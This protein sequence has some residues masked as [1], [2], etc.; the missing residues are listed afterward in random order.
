MF[1]PCSTRSAYPTF[2]GRR[3]TMSRFRYKLG[4]LIR[5]TGVALCALVLLL[6]ACGG[7]SSSA[8]GTTVSTAFA[9]AAGAKTSGSE[10]TD[11]TEF[12]LDPQRSDATNRPTGITAQNVGRLRD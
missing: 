7:G 9:S 5:L 3:R 4:M 6:S 11:W 10:L 12:G 2:D 8:D 1:S